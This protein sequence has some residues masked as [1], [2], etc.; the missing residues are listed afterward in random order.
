MVVVTKQML[1][2][3]ET[4]RNTV[5]NGTFFVSDLQGGQFMNRAQQPINQFSQTE[6]DQQQIYLKS[7]NSS[8]PITLS[9]VNL[10]PPLRS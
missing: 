2:I 6:I 1:H 3:T 5:L 10:L 7:D 4:T 9:R 8:F